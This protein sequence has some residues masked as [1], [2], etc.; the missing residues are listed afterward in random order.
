MA[1]AFA[2]LVPM[3]LQKTKVIEKK[4]EVPVEQLKFITNTIVERITN[5]VPV[6]VEKR[7]EIPAEIPDEYLASFNFAINYINAP[8]VEQKYECLRGISEVSVQVGLNN[9]VKQII[10]EDSARAKFELK[11]RQLGIQ[12]NQKAER[13]ASLN[14]EGLWGK[15]DIV[16]T[17]TISVELT[18]PQ[19]VFRDDGLH[20]MVVTSWNDGAYGYAGRSAARDALPRAIEE[21]AEVFANAYLRANSSWLEEERQK[22]REKPGKGIGRMTADEEQLKAKVKGFGTGFFVTSN[23]YFVSSHHVIKSAKLINIKIN[24]NLLTANIVSVDSQN[25]VALLS[26]A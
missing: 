4:V 16:L 3:S 8:F 23:G 26:L 14:I 2:I 10:S 17:Y 25:D 13:A 22:K 18:E 9:A 1:V 15:D 24:T 21:K 19:V 5:T 7:V 12:I 20:R 6:V 11:L